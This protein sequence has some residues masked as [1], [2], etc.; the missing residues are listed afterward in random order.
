MNP[1]TEPVG[2]DT[3]RV[4]LEVVEG[5][6]VRVERIN[7]TGNVRSQ[8][9][10]LRREIP[11]VEGDVFTLRNMERARQR[12]INLGYFETVNVTTQP[13]S[14]KS[15]V[16]VHVEVTEKPTGAF[17]VGG[18]FS[19]VDNLI[20]TIDLTQ[21]NFLGRGWQAS[22]RIRA[23]ARTQQGVI[24]FTEPWLFDRPLSA[25]FDI[26]NT[27]RQFTEYDYDSLGAGL[28]LSHPFLEYW[29][30]STGY[31]VTRD[32]IDGVK[33]VEATALRDEVGVRVTSMITGAVARDSRDDIRR[34]VKGSVS[35]V[36][37]DFAGIGGDSRYIK[38]TGTTIHFFPIWLNHII[39]GR[40]EAAHGF[41]WSDEPL[42]LFERFYLGGPNTIRSFKYRRLSPQDDSGLR[43]G[44][45]TELLGNVEYIVPLPFELRVAGF[46]DMGNVY[47]FGTKVDPTNTREAAG[48]GIRWFSPFGPLRF[49]YGINLDRKKGEDFGAFHFSV[50]SPF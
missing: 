28:R 22:I 16:I 10:I 20:G 26:F 47:G 43:I 17:S 18:G 9:K 23:G 7:I 3:L 11:M 33:D 4:V 29:R 42:P 46:F 19:S 13:G 1:R 39:S 25:G 31:R 15:K 24:S 8:E 6:E 30:W 2:T 45:S 37:M 34:P 38:T 41:G 48:A 32:E 14:D 36:S 27:R 12:L 21:N 50:G 5:P 40:A 44:G 35:S 49:D